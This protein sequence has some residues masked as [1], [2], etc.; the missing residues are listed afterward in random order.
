M[1]LCQI[2]E[3]NTDPAINIPEQKTRNPGPVFPVIYRFCEPVPTVASAFCSWLEEVKP[4]V[5]YCIS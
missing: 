3:P 4:R 5:T 1:D 2:L